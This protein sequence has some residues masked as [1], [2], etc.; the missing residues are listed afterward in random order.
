MVT[1]YQSTFLE[2][3]FTKLTK[4]AELIHVHSSDLYSFSPSDVLCKKVYQNE[5]YDEV[6]S[7][8]FSQNTL[9]HALSYKLH[10]GTLFA[11]YTLMY[12]YIKYTWMN[13]S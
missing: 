2:I 11:K 6:H 8:V 10:S 12:F 7:K 5:H 3:H 4:L 13:I 1:G 9:E